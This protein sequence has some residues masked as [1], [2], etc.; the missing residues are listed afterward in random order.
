MKGIT[1]T[2]RRKLVDAGSQVIDRSP[3]LS[4]TL[5]TLWK[6]RRL[7]WRWRLSTTSE[8]RQVQVRD[9]SATFAVSTRSELVRSTQL[10][11]ER[12]VLAALLEDLDGDEVV[13]DVGACVGTYSCLIARRLTTGQV[14]GFEP[15]PMNRR[16]LRENL[17]DNA[18]NERWQIS[19][20]ALSDHSGNAS[21]A[22]EFREFGAGHHYLTE[23][24]TDVTVETRRGDDLVQE[25]VSPP[26]VL[27]IDVQGVELQVLTGLWETLPDVDVV[28]LEVHTSKCQRYGYT[29][30]DVE[31]RLVEAGF[32]I[33]ELQGPT[34]YR[35]DIYFIRATR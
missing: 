1:A 5:R 12:H 16:R 30:D 17:L 35:A 10:G 15:E 8:Y 18:A 23:A 20:Y 11:G 25:G 6:W 19:P 2:M 34:N 32:T 29:A 7:F 31:T 33:E 13:W 28:Y 21:L 4:A 14:V 9:T 26:T 27:K 24:D 22:S 3:L